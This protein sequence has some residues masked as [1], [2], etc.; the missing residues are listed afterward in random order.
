MRTLMAGHLDGPPRPSPKCGQQQLNPEKRTNCHLP[1]DWQKNGDSDKN[2]PW[3]PWTP[4]TRR[5]ATRRPACPYP[6]P[7]LQRSA[8][9]R[10]IGQTLRRR[11]WA[12]QNAA[13]EWECG[14][15]RQHASTPAS[16][17]CQSCH[18]PPGPPLIPVP[19]AGKRG[20][21]RKYSQ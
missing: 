16:A 6:A 13:F 12:P 10:R 21:P 2:A 9:H 17:S 4:W 3:S 20:G 8:S 14:M 15:A 11:M 5:A 7:A 18:S 19:C 1:K